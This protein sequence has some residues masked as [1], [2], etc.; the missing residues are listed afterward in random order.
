MSAD[1]KTTETPPAGSRV[2][3]PAIDSDALRANLQETAVACVELRPE[4]AVLLEAVRGFKGIHATLEELLYDISHPYRNWRLILPRYRSFVLK[5][6]D[7]YRRHERGPEAVARLLEILLAA[8]KENVKNETLHQQSAEALAALLDKLVL[9]LR[10]EELA[11]YHQTLR[12]IFSRLAELDEP[13]LLPLVQGQHS[14]KRLA[15]RLADKEKIGV[16]H[17]VTVDENKLV[18]DPN[19]PDFLAAL[20]R[21]LQRGLQL[22]YRYW[23]SEE[24][25]QPWFVSEC[26]SLCRGWQAGR[27][28]SEISHARLREHLATVDAIAVDHDENALL[29]LL[30]LPDH[31]DIVRLYKEIPDRLAGGLPHQ[32]PTTTGSLKTARCC[33]SFGSWTPRG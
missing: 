31:L 9:V 13:L 7:H 21:L 4:W 22:N 26:E 8:L 10:P 20:S 5:H 23:L 30:E 6:L 28:F 24:D 3:K 27:L 12:E 15:A 2:C 11:S 1:A 16:G 19:F 14:L 29:R 32:A 17:Q 33:S 18:S 25:P